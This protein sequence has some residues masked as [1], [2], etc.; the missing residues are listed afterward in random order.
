MEGGRPVLELPAVAT[1]DELL[2]R[3][4]TGMVATTAVE[5]IRDELTAMRNAA[6]Y[7]M[8]NEPAPDKVMEYKHELRAIEKLAKSLLVKEAQGD[9]A[10]TQLLGV[11]PA[12]E[13]PLKAT[14]VTRV[15]R[16]RASATTERK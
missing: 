10:Y 1:L 12:E 6:Y 11:A 14:T 9:A 2:A 8:M 4:R 16:R 3:S 15:R 7:K 5:L 13:K